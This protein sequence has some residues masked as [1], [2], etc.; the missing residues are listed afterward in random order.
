MITRCS[1]A[2][3][4]RRPACTGS[5]ARRRGPGFAPVLLGMVVVALLAI[6]ISPQYETGADGGLSART[7]GYIVTVMGALGAAAAYGARRLKQGAA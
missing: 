2:A 3:A 4:S 5:A 6:V 7:F 1:T